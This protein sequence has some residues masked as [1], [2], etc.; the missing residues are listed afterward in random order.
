MRITNQKN[1]AAGAMY[2]LMGL[3]TAVAATRYSMGTAARMGPGYFPFWTGIALALVGGTVLLGATRTSDTS[4]ALERWRFRGLVLV[5]GSVVVFG[6]ILVPAGLV[7][8]VI[9][10]VVI[11]SFASDEFSWRMTMLTTA[12]LLPMTLLIFVYGLNLSFPVL[13]AF[14]AD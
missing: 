12:V 4:G 8:A 14:L 9:A 6:L 10:L 13:P 1:F 7:V 2:I 3:A 11:S 5:L